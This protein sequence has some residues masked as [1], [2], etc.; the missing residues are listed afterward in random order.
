[1]VVLQPAAA[2]EQPTMPLHLWLRRVGGEAAV[3]LFVCESNLQIEGGGAY[4]APCKVG[5]STV[6]LWES[7]FSSGRM[8]HTACLACVD[9]PELC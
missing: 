4:H 6:P 8:T 1:M 9:T 2:S 5:C 3:V 7:L